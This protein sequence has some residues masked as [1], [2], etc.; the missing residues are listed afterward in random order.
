MSSSKRIYLKRDFAAGVYLSEAQNPMPPL[1]TLYVYTLYLFA[2]GRGERW[3]RE[4]GRGET[5][6]KAGSKQP[7][8]LTV[9]LSYKPA[10]KSLY[11]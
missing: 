2:Q 7:T 11:W 6:Y 1:H 3:T 10:T 4:K 8:W 9:S 5:V